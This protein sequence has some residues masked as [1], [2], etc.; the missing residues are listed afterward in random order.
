MKVAH[1]AWFMRVRSKKWL[2]LQPHGFDEDWAKA[3][4]TFLPPHLIVR[5]MAGQREVLPHFSHL[6]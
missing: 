2:R 6:Q 4:T 3:K 5:H 1:G